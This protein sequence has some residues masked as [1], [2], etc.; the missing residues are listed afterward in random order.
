[1][2]M[3]LF[4]FI[5]S[6]P[7]LLLAG[8]CMVQLYILPLC[9]SQLAPSLLR[10][11]KK[12]L[13]DTIQKNSKIQCKFKS[14][15]QH[16]LID[17]CGI[18][19]VPLRIGKFHLLYSYMKQSSKAI[20][21]FYYMVRSFIQECFVSAIIN[22]LFQFPL[23]NNQMKMIRQLGGVIVKWGPFSSTSNRLQISNSRIS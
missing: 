22:I 19:I 13:Q 16:Q 9:L 10:F 15:E 14:S 12:L 2:Q 18:S 3:L 20:S 6:C 5:K 23:D 11:E 7:S 4:S 8:L 21:Y 17:N 1:M